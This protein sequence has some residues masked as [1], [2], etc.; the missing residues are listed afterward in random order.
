MQEEENFDS[1]DSKAAQATAFGQES[2]FV[3]VR[4]PREGEVLGVVIGNFGGG[5]LQVQ[6]KDGQERLCRIPGKIRRTIWVREGDVVLVKPWMVE[7]DK[8]GDIIWRYNHLQAEWLRNK[9]YL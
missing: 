6:C 1:P 7:G 4:L 8:K 3:R 5:R 2:Q 9:K